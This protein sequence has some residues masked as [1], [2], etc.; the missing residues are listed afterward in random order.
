M[1]IDE[2][3]RLNPYEHMDE[4]LDKFRHV[5]V[6]RFRKIK[7][8]KKGLRGVV[9]S[10][11]DYLYKRSYQMYLGLAKYYY[12]KAEGKKKHPSDEWLQDFLEDYDFLTGYQYD[13]EWDRKRARTFELAQSYRDENKTPDLKRPMT[14]L[15]QQV[16]EKSIEIVDAATI[17]AYKDQGVTKVKWVTQRD[18]KVCAECEERDGKIFNID[19]LPDKHYNCR[20]WLMRY[21]DRPKDNRDN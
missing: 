14:L 4:E 2:L 19:E 6:K 17:K 18:N 16:T 3:N 7:T 12:E 13:P 5:L 8:V 1:K 11:Y 20:C 21:D 10:T 9:N 15:N